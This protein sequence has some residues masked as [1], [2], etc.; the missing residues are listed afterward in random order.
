[1]IVVKDFSMMVVKEFFHDAKFKSNGEMLL[2]VRLGRLR[3][4]AMQT[5]FLSFLLTAVPAS[6]ARLRSVSLIL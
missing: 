6:A 3:P 5:I 4:F 2:C 1:M